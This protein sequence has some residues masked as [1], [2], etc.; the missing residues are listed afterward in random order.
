MIACSPTLLAVV[1]E[2]QQCSISGPITRRRRVGI[3]N[4]LTSRPALH[5][6]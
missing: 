3:R 5:R 4:G 6:W 1:S 2:N